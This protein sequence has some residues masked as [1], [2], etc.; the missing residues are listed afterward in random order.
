MRDLGQGYAAISWSKESAEFI[1]MRNWAVAGSGAVGV[2]GWGGIVQEQLSWALM[3]E[4]GFSWQ[5]S[6]ERALRA[7]GSA[8]ADIQVE[9]LCPKGYLQW[10][11]TITMAANID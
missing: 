1:P 7:E 2:G 8:W 5:R 6:E 11:I 10:I 4:W 9:R 3:A